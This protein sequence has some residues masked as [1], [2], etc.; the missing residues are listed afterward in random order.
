MLAIREI[1]P[2]VL[3]KLK[4]PETSSRSRLVQEWAAIAGPRLAGH[5]R[6]SLG[7]RGELYVWVDQS[8]LA[9]ELNQKYRPALLKRVQAVLGEET[10]TSVHVR[11][12]QLR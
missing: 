12:G 3:A 8:T 9:F 4:A 10:V 5:T 6:P 7:K 2:A 1:L 11:V